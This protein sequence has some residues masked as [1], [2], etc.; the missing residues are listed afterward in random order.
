MEVFDLVAGG[1]AAEVQEHSWA[2]VIRQVGDY[3]T[4]VG[5]FE[6]IKQKF[7]FQGFDTRQVARTLKKEGPSLLY[8]QHHEASYLNRRTVVIIGLL[9]GAHVTKMEKAM[10]EESKAD[11]R[12]LVAHYKIRSSPK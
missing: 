1:D 9:R 4:D 7:E 5:L 12:A 3:D 10:R 8:R 2:D 11:F 6:S